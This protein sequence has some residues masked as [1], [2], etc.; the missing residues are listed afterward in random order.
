MYTS[1]TMMSAAVSIVIS[2]KRTEK[3]L[4]Q[5]MMIE[6]SVLPFII[7]LINGFPW[8]PKQTPQQVLH[9]Q[10]SSRRRRRRCL[11]KRRTPLKCAAVIFVSISA[12]DLPALTA[13]DLI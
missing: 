12:G 8:R 11:F 10:G 5:V 7:E 9:H 1:I 4:G 13:F 3:N 2:K 6:L